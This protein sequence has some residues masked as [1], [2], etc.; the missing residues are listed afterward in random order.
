MPGNGH[1]KAIV[2]GEPVVTVTIGNAMV[3]VPMSAGTHTVRFVY[4]NKA[5]DLG[6]LASVGS[7]VALAGACVIMH[8]CDRRKAKKEHSQLPEVTDEQAQ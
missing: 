3:G 1:W 2:D 8:C 6:L 4:E 7:A 5:F